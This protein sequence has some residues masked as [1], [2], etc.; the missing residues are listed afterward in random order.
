VPDDSDD[1][2]VPDRHMKKLGVIKGVSYM[3]GQSDTNQ[4]RVTLYIPGTGRITKPVIGGAF[5]FEG[6]PEGR[7]E[8]II[9]PTLNDYNVRIIDV[10]LLAGETL[11]L[12]TVE[13]SVY[14]PN[15]V[16]DAPTSV[17]G[18]AGI[19][20][21]TVSWTLASSNGSAIVGYVATA[22]EDT[23]MRCTSASAT[24]CVVTGITKRIPYT[25][26]VTATNGVGE[27][28]PSAPSAPA[29]PTMVVPGAPTNVTARSGYTQVTASWSAPADNG[30]STITGYTVTAVQ[31]TSKHCTTTSTSCVLTNLI[32]GAVYTFTVTAT[33]AAGKSNP[34]S[35][36]AAVT[37]TIVPTDAPTGVKVVASIAKATV[38]W[39]VPGTNG[40]PTVT[41]YT[42]KSVED[43]S[44]H[45]NASSATSC[46]I[47]G[48]TNGATYSFT[49]TASNALGTSAPSAPSALASPSTIPGL[50]WTPQTPGTTNSLRSV[51]WTGTQLV[52]MGDGG[53]ILTSLNGVTWTSRTSGTTYPLNSVTWT[54]N[55]LVAVGGVNPV[56]GS[57]NILTSPDGVTWTSRILP[58]S[59]PI[60][61]VAW[62][63]TQLAA[64]GNNG[65]QCGNIATSPDGVTW[66]NRGMANTPIL[67]SVTWTGSTFM[68]VGDSGNY[69]T[70]AQDGV[71]WVPYFLETKIN[72]KFVTWA[73]DQLIAVGANGTILTSQNGVTWTARTSGTT[74]ALYSVTWTGSQLIAVGANGTILT[75]P[76]GVNW[77]MR[78]S[79]VINVLYSIT[80]TGSQLVAVGANGTILTSP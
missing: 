31:D 51:I 3:P 29:T 30:G 45:C 32:N 12:G 56:G 72:L 50:N 16:P 25:F 43:T 15:T 38:S 36:S 26:T 58:Y 60:F 75:S 44:K 14:Q 19:S 33:N 9:D 39:V 77:T 41:S 70:I 17:T 48:L 18:V 78:S 20:K 40:G 76:D 73:N 69:M 65:S 7:Y 11:D 62:S 21:V 1:V 59:Y 23:N 68:A 64:V 55:Q 22:V 8:I 47:T 35:P 54:G 63:G 79:G 57:S 24:S 66:T 53:T 61:S 10:I 4:V 71:T 2:Q 13:L 67:T 52:T 5:T 6:V 42:V 74:N 46:V 28:A 34:S 80:W 49:V 27:S 37:P